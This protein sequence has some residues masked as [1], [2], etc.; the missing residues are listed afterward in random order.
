MIWETSGEWGLP[1]KSGSP[2]Q[3]KKLKLPQRWLREREREREREK[4]EREMRDERERERDEFLRR[5]EYPVSG[6][7][8][9]MIPETG[10]CGSDWI[11]EL[12][13]SCRSSEMVRDDEKHPLPGSVVVPW[14]LCLSWGG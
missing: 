6:N 14:W 13:G 8:S 4:W 10:Q 12:V 7:L 3:I 2:W 11:K 1:R 9:V 5:D